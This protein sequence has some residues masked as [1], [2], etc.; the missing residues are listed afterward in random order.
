M[1][2]LV[3]TSFESGIHL[4]DCPDPVAKKGEVIIALRAAALNHRDLWILKGQYAG[5]K[6]PMILGS[7]GVGTVI[8]CGP[9]VPKSWLEK[10]VIINPGFDW[11]KDPA[12]QSKDFKILGLP[13]QGTFAERIAVPVTQVAPRAEHLSIPQAAA[14]PLAGLTAY[15]AVFTRAKLKKDENMLI[16]GIG[17]GVALFALQFAVAAGANVFVTSGSA[18]KI[19][20]AIKMG[21]QEGVLYRDADWIAQLEKMAGSFQV[22]IDSAGGVGFSGLVDVAAPGGRI[23]FFGATQ[24]N[25]TEFNMRKVFWKQLNI[26]GTTMG[27]PAEFDA[28]VQFVAENK[29][30]PVVHSTYPLARASEAF[31]VMDQGEQFGKLVLTI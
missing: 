25:P 22:I 9:D 1:K 23:A 5:I 4:E 8:E 10:E 21:A 26:L 11:G 3:I 7:D 18:E 13:D 14:L 17:G 30:T 31:A 12:A 2:A 24:G 27:T 28:M 16:A 15:R 20:R 29:I 6:Y 19:R